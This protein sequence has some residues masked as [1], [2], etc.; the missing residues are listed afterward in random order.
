MQSTVA[1]TPDGE[2]AD[3]TTLVVERLWA[4]LLPLLHGSVP[5]E[6]SFFTL[7]GTS[8]QA[9]ALAAQLE[10]SFEIEVT[11]LDIVD[12]PTLAALVD[13]VVTLRANRQASAGEE[14]EGEL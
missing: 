1:V 11:V 14:E 2:L 7:G 12:H 4:R 10:S 3:E 8:L 13:Y 5:R 9:M 6:V